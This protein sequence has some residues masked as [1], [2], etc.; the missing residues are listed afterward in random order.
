MAHE[1]GL[2]DTR[3]QRRFSG[4]NDGIIGTLVDMPVM[5]FNIL[6]WMM[7]LISYSSN[8]K[9]YYREKQKRRTSCPT[10]TLVVKVS[11]NDKKSPFYLVFYLP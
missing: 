3:M 9:H 1:Y 6:L 4:R 2:L 5:V 11:E 8:Y 10:L 7:L